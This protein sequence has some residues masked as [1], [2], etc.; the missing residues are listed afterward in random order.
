ML[1]FHGNFLCMYI[2]LFPQRKLLE[3]E[4]DIWQWNEVI[5]M[6]FQRIENWIK[7]EIVNHALAP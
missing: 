2:L 3:D 1:C 6:E 5:V 4:H 7:R